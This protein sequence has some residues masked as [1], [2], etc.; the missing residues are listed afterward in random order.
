MQTNIQTINELNLFDIDILTHCHVRVE[1]DWNYSN[2]VSSFSRLFYVKEGAASIICNGKQI[3]LVPGNVYLV[4]AGTCASYH[5]ANGSY[6]NKLFFHISLLSAENHDLL[7]DLP[8]N[9]YELPFAQVR[10]NQIFQLYSNPNY[11]TLLALRAILYETLVA[12]YRH[13]SFPIPEIKA[14]SP[15][16]RN[17]M[18]FIQNHFSAALT[19]EQIAEANFVS[20]GYLC[21]LFKKETGISVGKYIDE[22]LFFRAKRLLLTKKRVYY[23]ANLC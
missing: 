11:L 15:V 23:P 1:D 8:K 4:P 18:H 7:A 20:K 22:Q 5:C 3:P 17:V 12:F 21:K 19:I 16:T 2:V 13:F 9:V 10:C 6:M 14:Y